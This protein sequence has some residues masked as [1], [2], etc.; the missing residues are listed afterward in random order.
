M[1]VL[2][3]AVAAVLRSAKGCQLRVV[4]ALRADL[5]Q[6]LLEAGQQENTFDHD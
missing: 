2:D 4:S 3:Q 1:S 5:E 6:L